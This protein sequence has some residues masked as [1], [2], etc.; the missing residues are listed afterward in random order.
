[1]SKADPAKSGPGRPEIDPK[2]RRVSF[3]ISVDP[4]TEAFLKRV[5]GGTANR[6][7]VVDKLVGLIDVI[8][9]AAAAEAREKL[10]VKTSTADIDDPESTGP[11]V[12]TPR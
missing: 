1:M 9:I 6:G 3:G 11:G 4:R 5:A 12:P 10:Q 7:V 2:K 8:A